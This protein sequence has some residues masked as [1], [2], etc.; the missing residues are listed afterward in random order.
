MI[1]STFRPCR[2]SIGCTNALAWR[3]PC[4][5]WVLSHQIFAVRPPEVSFCCC[6]LADVPQPEKDGLQLVKVSGVL[7]L[8]RATVLTPRPPP[9]G[10]PDAYVRATNNAGALVVAPLERADGSEILVMRG[11]YPRS[12]APK[13]GKEVVYLTGI[14]R[15]SEEVNPAPATASALTLCW[16]SGDLIRLQAGRLIYVSALPRLFFPSPLPAARLL[17]HCPAA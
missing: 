4:L 12:E 16:R 14:L 9:K 13:A 3:S 8:S 17:G 6:R 15:S 5:A 1:R 10:L 11:W 7:D 2:E